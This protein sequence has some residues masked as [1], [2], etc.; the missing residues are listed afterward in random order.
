MRRTPGSPRTATLFPYTTLFRSPIISKGRTDLS[1]L[2]GLVME[3]RSY[4]R[5]GLPLEG[6]VVK[7][8]DG[9]WC[10]SRAKLVRPDFTQTINGH[11]RGD[12]TSTRVNY[13]N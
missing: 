1:T 11:W 5:A 3:A 8:Q 7:K 9:G 13:S 12:R 10:E 2:K 6:I 4:Y